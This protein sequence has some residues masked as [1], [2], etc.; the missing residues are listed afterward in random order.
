MDREDIVIIGGGICGLATALALHRFVLS[1]YFF[2]IL[3]V[4]MLKLEKNY[5]N[6]SIITLITLILFLMKLSRK[7]LKSVV[8]EK[9]ETLRECGVVISILTNGWRALD[10]L[11]VASKLRPVSFPVFGYVCLSPINNL[12]V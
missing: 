6:I 4:Y 12:Y 11:G 8:L 9:S 2:R 3:L 1:R 5:I 10:Q 7:G